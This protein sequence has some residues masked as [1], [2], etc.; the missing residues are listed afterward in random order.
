MLRLI[1][2]INAWSL[3]DLT[4]RLKSIVERTKG[5]IFPTFPLHKAVQPW[6][7]IAQALFVKYLKSPLLVSTIWHGSE[8][9]AATIM[10]AM[11]D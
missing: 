5:Q 3:D 9:H 6:C 2:N 1:T 4:H 8:V 7:K 11:V 10:Y